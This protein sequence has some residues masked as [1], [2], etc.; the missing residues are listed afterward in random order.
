M[1]VWSFVPLS[2]GVVGMLHGVQI[3]GCCT[4]L[5][6]SVSFIG[7]ITCA[8][9]A[10]TI[11][12]GVALSLWYCLG[13]VDDCKERMAPHLKAGL[14]KVAMV[15]AACFLISVTWSYV[16]VVLNMHSKNAKS[17][18]ELLKTA[19]LSCGVVFLCASIYFERA[20]PW[21]AILSTSTL[22]PLV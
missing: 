2:V 1:V 18:E 3:G 19:C 17:P 4:A 22:L 5:A 12:W 11:E 9:G 13:Y 15:C 20:S 16:S 6:L 21:V 10:A 7:M 8:I 14:S